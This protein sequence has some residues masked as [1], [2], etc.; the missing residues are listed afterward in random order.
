MDGQFEDDEYQ[1]GDGEDEGDEGD[2]A[3]RGRPAATVA[4]TPGSAASQ[5]TGLTDA[6][7]R[8]L[9]WLNDLVNDDGNQKALPLTLVR[10]LL[11]DQEETVF[12]LTH[13]L[14]KNPAD[15]VK[16]ILAAAISAAQRVFITGLRPADFAVKIDGKRDRINFSFDTTAP[17]TAARRPTQGM[18]RRSDYAPDLEGMA[19]QQMD[20]NIDYADRIVDLATANIDDK[21]RTIA[22]LREELRLARK[23]EWKLRS[24]LEKAQ[25]FSMRRMMQMEEFKRD[26]DR[27]DMYAEGFKNIAPPVVATVLGPEAGK[28]AAL[29]AA[30]TS[31]GDGMLSKLLG[32]ALGGVDPSALGA[33]AGG[34]GGPEGPDGEPG[35]DPQFIN[36]AINTFEHIDGFI[37]AV[38][39]RKGL[40]QQLVTVLAPR[41]PDCIPHLRALHTDSMTRRSARAGSQPQQQQAPNGP[42]GNG[43]HG[44]A[45]SN[46]AAS[47]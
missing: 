18:I 35:I 16:D 38:E 21:D 30:F 33:M 36:A 24:A 39:R 37:D 44:G 34:P 47:R 13:P 19:S 20:I 32:G 25:D 8:L 28:A 31:S 14:D 17:Q 3:P 42:N 9:N 27:K 40:F 5:I 7:P 1:D 4:A 6:G 26:Q 2:D 45:R 46:S 43:H 41:A 29:L 15:T 11:N 10:T 12:E 22:T 23:V